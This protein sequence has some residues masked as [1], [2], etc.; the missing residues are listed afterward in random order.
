MPEETPTPGQQ[1]DGQDGQQGG[2]QPGQSD[3]TFS[4]SELDRIVQDRLARERNKYADYDDLRAKASRLD[5]IEQANASDLE[6]AQKRAEEAEARAKTAAERA[7]SALRRAAVVAEATRAGAVDPDAVL[8]LLPPDAV[9]VGDDGQVTGAED[10]VRALLEQ[11][12]YLVGQTTPPPPPR[13]GTTGSAEGGARGT[14]A[15]GPPQLTRAD[16]VSMSHQEIAKAKQE[17]RL[18]DLLSGK[19]S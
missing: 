13:A 2:Q 15:D 10:A 14:S 8:A 3:R 19:T 5:E 11:K 12:P 18:R 1:T 4:Q 6:K 17:G 16:L 7:T 9:T